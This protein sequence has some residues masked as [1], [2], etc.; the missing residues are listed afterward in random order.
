MPRLLHTADWQLGRRARSARPIERS[1]SFDLRF[2]AVERLAALAHAHAVDAVV[3]AGD[4]FADNQVGTTVLQ[5]AAEVLAAFAP[6]P[7]VLVPGNHDAAEPGG[8]L[9]RLNAGAHVHVALTHAPIA[10][11]DLTLLPCPLFKRLERGDPTSHVE[12]AEGLRVVIT[13][14]SARDGAQGSTPNRVD[15]AALLRKG[16]A[17]VALGD[18]PATRLGPR[19]AYAGPPVDDA[20]GGSAILVELGDGEPALTTLATS[21]VRAIEHPVEH[22]AELRTATDVGA[23]STWLAGLDDPGHALVSL[24]ITGA[25]R[26]PDRARLDALLNRDHGLLGFTVDDTVTLRLDEAIA[27]ADAPG[28]LGT[29]LGQLTGEPDAAALLLSWLAETGGAR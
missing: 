1:R 22:G 2:Q 16:V 29:A 24:R 7:V 14:G 23:L 6:I 26:P 25:L 9:R 20:P 12:R 13:H 17:Y 3:V 5:R 4:V 11:G 21:P 8:A 18:L 15:V 27:A 28:F 19:A 10:V